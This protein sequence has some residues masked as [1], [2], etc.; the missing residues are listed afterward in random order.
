MRNLRSLLHFGCPLNPSIN[1][2]LELMDFRLLVR[3]KNT[4]KLLATT[5]KVKRWLPAMVLL[6]FCHGNTFHIDLTVLVPW[7]WFAGLQKEHLAT[8]IWVIRVL[9]CMQVF[10]AQTSIF[11]YHANI[12]R[13]GSR[14]FLLQNF[15]VSCPLYVFFHFP[16]QGYSLNLLKGLSG[17]SQNT[18]LEFYWKGTL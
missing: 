16:S 17:L 5:G 3:D 10:Q 8:L 13:S 18:Q 14:I 2:S 12:L 11:V 6:R 7:G 9:Y 15:P 1:L 4:Q